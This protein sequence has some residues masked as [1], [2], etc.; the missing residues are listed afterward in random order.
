M[1]FV[2]PTMAPAA[3]DMPD[4]AEPNGR[5]VARLEQ[6]KEESRPTQATVK[7]SGPKQDT[8][9]MQRSIPITMSS[10][11]FYLSTRSVMAAMMILAPMYFRGTGNPIYDQ[12]WRGR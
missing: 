1:R 12:Q 9:L 4:D 8:G 3:V 10:G 6:M 2:R 11:D 7:P 5:R